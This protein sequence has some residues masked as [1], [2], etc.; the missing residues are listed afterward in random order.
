MSVRVI[1]SVLVGKLT[2]LIGQSIFTIIELTSACRA[3]YTSERGKG[4]VP[5]FSF[6]SKL[7]F[8]F[9]GCPEPDEVITLDGHRW[10]DRA[11]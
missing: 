8:S 10:P 4:Y 7:F 1:Y 5:N 11:I 9:P 6:S 2:V 3:G